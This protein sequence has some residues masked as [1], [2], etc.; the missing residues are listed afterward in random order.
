MSGGVT[1]R[2]PGLSRPTGSPSCLSANATLKLRP[3]TFSV[4]RMIA[5]LQGGFSW[6]D[7][8]VSSWNSVQ[9]IADGE[10]AA[11]AHRSGRGTVRVLLEPALGLAW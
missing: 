1:S 3:F 7:V 9:A 4:A 2:P 11:A 10:L 6:R 8:I 5:A